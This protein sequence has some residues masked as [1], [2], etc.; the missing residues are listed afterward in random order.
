MKR[1]STLLFF[2]ALFACTSLQ[3]QLAPGSI[4]PNFTATDLDGNEWTLY[5]LTDQGYS[6]I[7][8]FSATWCGPCWN[9]HHSGN[10]EGVWEQ[11]GPDGTN[12]FM[13]LMIEGDDDTSVAD[14]YGNGNNTIGDWVTGTPY[15]IINDDN[16]AGAYSIGY[17]PTVYQVCPNRIVTEVSPISTAAHYNFR[18]TCQFPSGENNAGILSYVGDEGYICGDFDLGASFIFQNLGTEILTSATFELELDGSVVS[19]I[20]WTGELALYEFEEISFDAIAVDG[21]TD[22]IVRVTSANGGTD[23]DTANDAVDFAVDQI[24]VDQQILT[25]ELRTDQYP[26]ETYWYVADE[27][28]NTIAEG[29]NTAVGPNGG[30]VGVTP[31]SGGYNPNSLNTEEIVLPA[32]G[33]Y[34]FTVVDS[35]GDGICCNYGDGFYRLSDAS[36]TVLAQG[37]EFVGYADIAFGAELLVDV[38][39]LTSVE[40]LRMF[41][42]PVSER[43][44]VNFNMNEADFL[45][46]EVFN[47]LGQRVQTVAGDQ[48]A[49]GLHTLEVN[50]QELNSGVYFLRMRSGERELSRRFVVNR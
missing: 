5:D 43:M 9:Y 22:G 39:E 37:G 29:G 15:P 8:D 1:I 46:V 7:L 41:P 42:N 35:Y 45:Q 19:T 23:D 3:A 38:E 32:D 18:N 17:W 16:L 20:D 13:V 33:C 25:L 48:F 27:N 12:E 2:A 6:V 36:G 47:T 10:L 50:A 49:T 31:G 14:L 21:S 11:Y 34:S 26:T 30:D 40:G 24:I 28:G 44:T 4:A